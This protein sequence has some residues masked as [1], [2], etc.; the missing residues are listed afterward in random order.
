M[1]KKKQI[2]N[3]IVKLRKLTNLKS[4][5]SDAKDKAWCTMLALQWVLQNNNA[6]SIISPVT[7]CAPRLMKWELS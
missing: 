5:S 1:R 7:I 3:E 6:K 4:A 2:Q